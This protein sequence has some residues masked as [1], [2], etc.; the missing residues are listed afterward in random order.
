MGN[1]LNLN[2]TF[3][4]MLPFSSS[5]SVAQTAQTES[6][7]AV[8]A[9][10]ETRTDRTRDTSPSCLYQLGQRLAPS[11]AITSC[12]FSLAGD[13]AKD[14]IADAVAH[15]VQCAGSWVDGGINCLETRRCNSRALTSHVWRAIGF[16]CLK[17]QDSHILRGKRRRECSVMYACSVSY[18][19]INLRF[20]PARCEMQIC[21]QYRTRKWNAAVVRIDGL[22]HAG[23]RLTGYSIMQALR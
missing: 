18:S 13:F 5:S 22:R 1:K 10:K 9:V 4:P 15:L 23:L 8:A 16:S 12:Q 2:V 17:M 7:P 19:S 11:G 6:S 3:Y 20:R 14:T 21:L